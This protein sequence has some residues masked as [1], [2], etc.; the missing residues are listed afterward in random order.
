[1]PTGTGRR[2]GGDD[3]HAGLLWVVEGAAFGWR[4]LHPNETDVGG[5]KEVADCAIIM[6]SYL[7]VWLI[8]LLGC[9]LGSM[10]GLV[11]YGALLILYKA[12]ESVWPCLSKEER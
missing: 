12:A 2:T 3:W 9:W 7:F 6:V 1:V 4:P 5:E 11:L 8:Y 10:N